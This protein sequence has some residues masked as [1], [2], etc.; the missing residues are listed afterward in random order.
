MISMMRSG[1]TSGLALPIAF[2]IA[3]TI[4]FTASFTAASPASARDREDPISGKSAQIV[5]LTRVKTSF[6]PRVTRDDYMDVIFTEG[7]FTAQAVS[8]TYTQHGKKLRFQVDEERLLAF[9]DSW[10]VA[11][12]QA[13]RD[14]GLDPESVGCEITK[15]KLK[16]RLRRGEIKFKSTYKIRCTAEGDFGEDHA[17]GRIRFRGR[18]QLNDGIIIWP[19]G[20]VSR[21]LP[22]PLPPGPGRGG[23]VTVIAAPGGDL[24]LRDGTVE[25]EPCIRCEPTQVE[26]I[27]GGG[28]IEIIGGGSLEISVP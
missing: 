6:G 26:P 19:P 16:G 11:Y 3:A 13:L 15:A 28:S 17:T 20:P 9:E 1:W 10:E 4:A 23:S 8:G 2:T 14:R 24:V 7:R 5:G 27:R 25:L 12:E 18:G 22:L 21:P